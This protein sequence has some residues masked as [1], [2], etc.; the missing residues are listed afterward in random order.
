MEEVL[1]LYQLPYDSKRPVI[2]YDERPCQL[3]GDVLVPLPVKPGHPKREDYHYQRHGVCNVLIAFEPATGQRFVAVT[4]RRTGKD[5]AQFMAEI[6][7]VHYPEAEKIVLVQDNL[8]TH[9]PGSFYAAFNPEEAFALS[10]RF[11]MHYTPTNASWLNMVEIELSA[12]SR[13]CL[14]RRIGEMVIDPRTATGRRTFTFRS[15]PT[16]WISKASSPG[17]PR[18]ARGI[19]GCR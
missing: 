6:A 7:A 18:R 9:C 17:S 15:S 2:C 13:Q 8:N 10:E 1:H 3:I 11:E 19:Y 12:L 5:Y 14:C 16:C 4:H